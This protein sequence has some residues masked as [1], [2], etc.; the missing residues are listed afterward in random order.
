MHDG[1]IV[2]RDEALHSISSFLDDG[3][4]AGA[5]LIQGGAGIGKTTIWRWGVADASKRGRQVLAAS[6]AA[7]EAPLAFAA[8]GDLLAEAAVEVV[9][10]LPPP[11]RHALE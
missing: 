9:A 6:P 5:L 3:A 1:E 8:L 2:G 4:S 10:H 7:A 11:Q